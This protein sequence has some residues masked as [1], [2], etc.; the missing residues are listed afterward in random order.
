MKFLPITLIATL[1]ASLLMALIFVPTLGATFG[2][3]G[4]ADA[5]KMK[6]LAASEQGE[7]GDIGGITGVYILMLRAAT[8]R[9]A[10]I[11]AIAA[12][13]LVGVWWYYGSHGNGVEFF[14]EVEP[15]QAIVLIHARGNLS[16]DEQD[17]LVS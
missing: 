14:P 1:S 15:E 4:P 12:A 9:P 8:R 2:K 16:I 6:A 11:V 10:T 5:K 17:V 7:V 13:T 3:P